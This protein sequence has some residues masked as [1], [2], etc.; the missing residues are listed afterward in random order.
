VFVVAIALLCRLPRQAHTGN[1]TTTILGLIS[2]LFPAPLLVPS[3]P[4]RGG[5][6]RQNEIEN[7]ATSL[8][9]LSLRHWEQD[10]ADEFDGPHSLI[11]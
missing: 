3:V 7:K 8:D 5:P 1:G 2:F 4:F 10:G 6:P 11:R 9:D